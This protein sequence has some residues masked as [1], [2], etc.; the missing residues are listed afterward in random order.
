MRT[1]LIVAV[2]AAL[3]LVTD[4]SGQG[5]APANGLGKVNPF[6]PQFKPD[7]STGNLIPTQ[8][9]TGE[10]N[11]LNNPYP[12]LPWNQLGA[13]RVDY[14]EVVQYIAV[15]PQPAAISLY[16]PVPDGVPPQ[17]WEGTVEVPGYYVAETTTGYWYPERWMLQQLNLGVYQWVKLPAEFRRK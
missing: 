14:G 13:F 1:A 8:P 10:P 6:T 7:P 5:Q 17:T 3:V 9:F 4:A 15:P 12:T 11:H 16:V 2:V